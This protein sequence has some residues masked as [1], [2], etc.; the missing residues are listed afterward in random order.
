MDKINKRILA[1]SGDL[2]VLHAHEIK[3]EITDALKI[4]DGLILDLTDSNDI[5]ITFLQI[6][7]AAHKTAVN[8]GKNMEI[9]KD[10]YGLIK[11]VLYRTG[12]IRQMGCL[13]E[14][15]NDCLFKE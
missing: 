11:K 9:N 5:D 2:T 4:S 12:F 14:N 15:K 10:S 3:R 6:L 8:V 13:R 7:C 1:L